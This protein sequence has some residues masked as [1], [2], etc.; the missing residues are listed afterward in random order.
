M[1][2]LFRQYMLKYIIRNKN[3]NIAIRHLRHYRQSHCLQHDS[4]PHLI[5]FPSHLQTT[6]QDTWNL[7][8]E[9][10]RVHLLATHLQLV[11]DS[12]IYGNGGTVMITGSKF[13]APFFQPKVV[14]GGNVGTARWACFCTKVAN[15]DLIRCCL[16]TSA[17]NGNP[18]KSFVFPPL[19]NR[20]ARRAAR[21]S[22]DCPPY[23]AIRMFL[24][25]VMSSLITSQ[26]RSSP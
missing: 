20:C 25:S 23:N 7:A 13:V 14:A 26:L 3:L 21:D 2:C 10:I 16:K 11:S 4:R 18:L 15:K 1:I 12:V 6:Q 24:A 17:V 9:Q 22:N 19:M 8:Q 5:P